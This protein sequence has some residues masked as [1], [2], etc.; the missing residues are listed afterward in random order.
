MTTLSLGVEQNSDEESDKSDSES[1]MEQ[2]IVSFSLLKF[3][4]NQYII[5]IVFNVLLIYIFLSSYEDTI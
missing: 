3:E 1:Y 2:C 4:L 5:F